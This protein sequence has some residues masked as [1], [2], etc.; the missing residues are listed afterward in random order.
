[1][2]VV[3]LE[4][5]PLTE[6]LVDDI[7]SP[8]TDYSIE[9]KN[10]IYTSLRLF[11]K[12]SAGALKS[13]VIHPATEKHIN[14]YK[15][16]A[17]FCVRETAS[18]YNNITLPYITSSSFSLQWLY[19]LLAK[20]AEV[21]R[22]VYEDDDQVNGFMLVPDLKWDCKQTSNLYLCAVIHRRDIKSIR[23]LRGEHVQLLENIRDKGKQAIREKYQFNVHKL[24][25]YFHY[26][27]SYYH[28]HVH[29]ANVSY[30]S[31][32]CTL[33]KA[34]AIDDVIDNLKMD[35]DYY[36]KCSLTYI[37]KENDPLLEKFKEAGR[38]FD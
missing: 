7:M 6:D 3:I 24:R 15:Q 29:F 21:D 16:H 14:K 32:S 10:D 18:D 31:P 34:H 8:A 26:Q 30:N 12:V 33:G 11:P 23:D 27:P 1:N 19:N 9:M 25:I 22:I 13:T 28:L 20:K 5:T 4:R 37:L 35:S 2:V 38:C 36:S 17:V